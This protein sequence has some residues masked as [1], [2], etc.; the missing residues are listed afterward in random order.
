MSLIQTRLVVASLQ[1]ELL[2]EFYAF[3]VDG[4]IASGFHGS[5]F[6]VSVSNEMNIHFYKP[7]RNQSSIQ[8]NVIAICLE[9]PPS[10][11]P[12]DVIKIWSSQLFSRGGS[13]VEDPRMESFGAESWMTDPEGNY[14][15]IFVLIK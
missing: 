14:F 3:A 6:V 8:G 1:P 2:A 13:F 5:H 11:D 4:R 10:I 12:L 7:S 9:K 15:L